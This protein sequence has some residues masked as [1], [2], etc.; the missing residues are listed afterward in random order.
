[1]TLAQW[2]DRCLEKHMTGTVR[3]GT[4]KGY[5]KD[6]DNHVK[7]CLGEKLLMKLTSDDLQE[8]YRH[9]LERG[10]KHPQQNC[11]PGL[12]RL[13]SGESTPPSTTH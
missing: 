13:P 3:P 8:L 4:L 5:R 1:M 2:L 9:L 7:P 12:A 6:M 10:R 11:G